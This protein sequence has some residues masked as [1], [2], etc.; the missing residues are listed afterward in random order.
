MMGDLFWCWAWWVIW[1][2]WILGWIWCSVGASFLQVSGRNFNFLCIVIKESKTSDSGHIF[3]FHYS[4]CTNIR[5]RDLG[6]TQTG[7][8]RSLGIP[9]RNQKSYAR[10]ITSHSSERRNPEFWPP[11]TVKNQ[12]R[13]LV[14]QGIKNQMARHVMQFRDDCW[15]RAVTDW[16]PRDIKRLRGRPP[17]WSEFFVKTLN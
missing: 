12:G 5:L 15:T 7:W 13:C 17:R 8:E 9:K 11:S 14:C 2:Y 3:L 1:I 4:F 10:S 6:P 16:I